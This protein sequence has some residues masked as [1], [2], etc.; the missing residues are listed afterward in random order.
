M[1]FVKR[2]LL[3]GLL[4]ILLPVWLAQAAVA[5][6]EKIR[7]LKVGDLAPNIILS[8][9]QPLERDYYFILKDICGPKVSPSRRKFVILSFFDFGYD[10]GDCKAQVP[11]LNKIYQ[12]YQN[13]P[14]EMAVIDSREMDNSWFMK[15][16]MEAT[17]LKVPVLLDW[18]QA[19]MRAYGVERLPCSFLISREQ[20]VLGIYGPG[21]KELNRLNEEVK[22]VMAKATVPET[23]K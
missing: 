21:E 18:A 5:E 6:Q 13:Q 17:G 23:Q 11:Q 9:L 14:L 20:R 22:Q 16:F 10:A 19:A 12:A 1:N 2:R 7:T 4:A 3:W 8:R 15:M